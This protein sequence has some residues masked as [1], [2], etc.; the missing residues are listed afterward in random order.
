MQA[1]YRTLYTH[2]PPRPNTLA[3]LA[4]HRA[5]GLR[6]L[7]IWNR[8]WGRISKVLAKMTGITP[9][10][11]TFIGRNW[12]VPPNARR[13]RMCRADWVGMRRWALVI[14]TTPTTTA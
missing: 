7:M 14:A 8:N 9:A 6:L 4:A 10:A 12:R 5:F 2:P 11:F 1:M 3:R 13:P